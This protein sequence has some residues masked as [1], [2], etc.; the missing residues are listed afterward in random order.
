MP[1]FCHYCGVRGR[2]YHDQDL[3]SD[4]YI[5]YICPNKHIFYEIEPESQDCTASHLC[6]GGHIGWCLK[7]EEHDGEHLC[8]QCASAFQVPGEK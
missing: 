7:S 8:G 1:D 4:G 2:H 5:T 3:Q 6:Q